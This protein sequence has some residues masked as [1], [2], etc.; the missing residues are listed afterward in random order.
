MKTPTAQAVSTA[1][2]S[3]DEVRLSEERQSF[4]EL[5]WPDERRSA[6]EIEW[7]CHASESFEH[8]HGLPAD[9]QERAGRAIHRA[10]RAC[11]DLGEKTP[12]RDTLWVTVQATICTTT[13]KMVRP[14]GSSKPFLVTQEQATDELITA[15]TWLVAH[16]AQARTYTPLNLFVVLRGVATKSGSGSARAAQS[17]SLRGITEVPPGSTVGWG[18]LNEVDAA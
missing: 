9:D 17:D 12:A 7:F 5:Q 14:F 8:E 16:E 2:H 18:A 1:A 3:I 10:L 4:D 15:M 6:D 11:P 13:P